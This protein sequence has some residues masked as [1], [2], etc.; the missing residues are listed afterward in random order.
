[1]KIIGIIPSRYSSTRFPGKPLIDIEGKTM[2]QRVYEQ[3]KECSLLTDL[4]VATDDERIYNH[5]KAFGGNV[6]MTSS[7][8]T[9]GTERC[10][11]IAEKLNTDCDDIIINIQG[12]EPFINPIQIE[13]LISC[14]NDAS[15]DIATLYKKIISVADIN[16]PNV[17]KVV[18]SFNSD[19]IYFSRSPIPFVR[20]SAI[21]D[22]ISETNF[23]KHIGIYGYRQSILERIV[24][25]STGELEK[26][27]SL[28]QLRWLESGFKIKVKET[29]FE[30]M[31]IDTPEDYFK[32]MNM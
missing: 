4:V 1:M 15:T 7:T 30:S 32:M 21:K 24:N 5:V 19:A 14:F 10:F 18:K 17:V 13:L 25:L 12:D 23:Y 22:W 26:A 20:G 31:A 11:E 29:D 28:E 27:E 8:H 9:S 2:I 6:I 3:S 16:N